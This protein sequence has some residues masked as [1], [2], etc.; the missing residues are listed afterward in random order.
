MIGRLITMI[1]DKHRFL[2]L[3]GDLMSLHSELREEMFAQAAYCADVEEVSLQDEK[4][5]ESKQL[6]SPIKHYKGQ[7]A[8]A[9]AL[10]AWKHYTVGDDC[11]TK[12]V[13]RYA[14]FVILKDM[15]A[16]RIITEINQ[17]KDEI[18]SCVQ[19]AKEVFE[20]EMVEGKPV[21][22]VR[23]VH[24][25]STYLKH[26]FIHEVA[27]RIMTLQLYRHIPVITR[28]IEGIS[29]Y[30]AN[31]SVHRSFNKQ[32]ASDFFKRKFDEALQNDTLQ[33]RLSDVENSEFDYF[34]INKVQHAALMASL[35]GN[36]KKH[37][38]QST[39]PM[40][41]TNADIGINYKD[42][43]SYDLESKEPV[44]KRNFRKICDRWHMY[45]VEKIKKVTNG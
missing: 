44:V 43:K 18:K 40:V 12:Y 4:I 7:K 8:V 35:Y 28:P 37:N 21:E 15:E 10:R 9:A 3:Y 33:R 39:T 41:L 45:G 25:R 42:L 1:N 2:T 17:L 19:D 32:E 22:R 23:T 31:K 30:W 26:K 34:E 24:G 29:F 13:K 38:L 27:P 16:L 36:S 11:S 6:S 14:G 5:M 20:I